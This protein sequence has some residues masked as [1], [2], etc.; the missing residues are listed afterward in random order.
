M[1]IFR[2]LQDIFMR[3]VTAAIYIAHGVRIVQTHELNGA[4]LIRR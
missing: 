2:I 1:P 4:A 3:L